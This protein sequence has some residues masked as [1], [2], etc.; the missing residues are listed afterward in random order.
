MGVPDGV[1]MQ[2][3]V[4]LTT[5]RQ[6]HQSAEEVFEN[7]V[8]Q[9][10]AAEEFGF[11]S[12]WI[13]E[14]HFT[15]YGLCPNS[16]T[17]AAHIL[18]ATKTLKVG[19][20]VSVV[21]LH[22]PVR[23][24]EDVG[25]LSQLGRGRFVLGVG[26][27]IYLREYEVFGI[28]VRTN[29]QRM[30]ETIDLLMA[31]WAGPVS[32]D[33]DLISFGT[34][35]PN[36]P[37]FGGSVPIYVAGTS[38]DTIEFAASRGLPLLLDH[39]EMERRIGMLELYGLASE[40]A[41]FD[42]GQVVHGVSSVAHVS[43]SEEDALAEVSERFEWW[44]KESDRTRED[45]PANKDA[46]YQNYASHKRAH[47]DRVLRGRGARD[48]RLDLATRL[49]PIGPPERCVAK[50]QEI[51]DTLGVRFLILGFEAGGTIDEIVKSMG[52]FASEVSVAV[53][54]PSAAAR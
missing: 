23:L 29:H 27:G 9:A 6:P 45:L 48:A 4:Y 40:D 47:E 16:L 54:P 50:V 24:I 17:M 25:L 8:I 21:P 14:H 42:P 26:R 38:P 36:P 39:H 31:S 5:A 13:L 15:D 30:Y 3:G 34:V 2:F 19:T 35:A 49:D 51:V 37:P 33:S 44:S 22:H 53:T 12:V 11:D 10:V 1:A 20:A 43:D 46:D 18:G 32:H 28:D 7:A 52:R 41:G